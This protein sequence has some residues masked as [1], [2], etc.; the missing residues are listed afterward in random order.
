M[1]LYYV[2]RIAAEID[3]KLVTYSYKDFKKTTMPSSYRKTLEDYENAAGNHFT[4]T[5]KQ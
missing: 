3:S 2:G 1:I 4:S 5:H